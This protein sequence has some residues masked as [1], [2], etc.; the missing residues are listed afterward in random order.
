[1]GQKD[2]VIL[3]QLSARLG[4]RQGQV[5]MIGL[6]LETHSSVIEPISGPRR[7]REFPMQ[8]R[9]RKRRLIAGGDQCR[10]AKRVRKAPIL[11]L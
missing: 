11:A 10:D 2:C 4:L 9:T 8:R 5:E 1:M 7:E 3:P 6:E